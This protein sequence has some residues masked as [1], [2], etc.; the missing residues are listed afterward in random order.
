MPQTKNTVQFYPP[1]KLIFSHLKM[2]SWNIRFLLGLGPGLFSVFRGYVSVSF[3]ESI[4]A[5]S[6]TLRR[7]WAFPTGLSL[8]EVVG[9]SLLRQ[10]FVFGR[11]R[12]GDD[13]KNRKVEERKQHFLLNIV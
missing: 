11:K 8:N 10:V 3:R 12:G 7:G 5:Q 2:D 13:V 1:L 6:P 4:Y 9:E